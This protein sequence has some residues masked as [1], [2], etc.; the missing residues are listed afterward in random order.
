MTTKSRPRPAK[1]PA[2]LRVEMVPI[3][4]VRPLKRNPR[5]GDVDRVRASLRRWG[6]YVP[7][8]VRAETGEIVKGNHTHAALKA[9]G[10]T[11]VAVV[12]RSIA[13]DAEAETLAIADNVA[14]D[15]AT[16]DVG[17]LSEIL[18]GDGIDIE[19]TLLDPVRVDEIHIE[20][21]AEAASAAGRALGG[22]ADPAVPD[23]PRRPTTRPGDVIRLGD[24]VLVCGD[25]TDPANFRAALDA[26]KAPAI[27]L[28]FT[29]PPY[30][31]G[32]R[33]YGQQADDQHE[34][35]DAYGGFLRRV[36]DAILP[37]IAAGRA[38]CWNIGVSPATFPAHQHLMLEDAGLTFHRQ[39]VWDKKLPGMPKWHLV[40]AAPVARNFPVEYQHELILVFTTGPL[41]RGAQL[42]ELDPMARTSVLGLSPINAR[43]DVPAGTHAAGAIE[44]MTGLD[45]AKRRSRGGAPLNRAWE[46]A[47]PAVFPVDLVRPFI[48]HLAAPGEIVAD[49]FGGAGTVALACEQRDRRAV[50]VEID[51]GYCDV[52]IERWETLTGQKAKRPRR[53]RTTRPKKE[54]TS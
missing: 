9:E 24:H 22:L 31:V 25:S 50:L 2:A 36:V 41:K 14:S 13:T 6:Q 30:N 47:H 18:N 42:V 52:A 34:S 48:G 35:W 19:A 51:P 37:S 33:Y 21:A 40:E 46:K 32:V 12:R 20:A 44:S 54:T 7:I 43:K 1:V 27:D 4:D 11:H 23:T 17:M 38:F 53:R 39:V 49:P 45:C 29:S 16:W 3:D 26:I 28:V 10:E 5:R 8:V 15:S